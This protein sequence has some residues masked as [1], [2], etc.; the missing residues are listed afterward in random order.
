MAEVFRNFLAGRQL[1]NQEQQAQNLLAQQSVENERQNQLMQMRQTEFGNAQQDRERQL[2]LDAQEMQRQSAARAA[3]VA[4]QAIQLGGAQGEGEANARA[5][6]RRSV[7]IYGKDFSAVADDFSDLTND[8][9]PWQQQVQNLQQIAAFGQ[10]ED[11]ESQLKLGNVNP[12]DFT[13]QSLRAYQQSID[14][15]TGVGDFS[16]LER[17]WAPPAVTVREFGGTSN[18][19]DP[20]NRLGGGTV[21]QLLTPE[22]E[23]EAKA[24]EA[25][26]V[27]GAQTAAKADAERAAGAAKVEGQAEDVLRTVTQLKNSPG[28]PYILG[29]YSKAPIVPNTAQAAADALAKQ[30]EGQTFLQAFESLKGGGQITEIEG[31]QAKQAVSRLSRAQSVADYTDAL[32]ELVM[33][34]NRAVRRARGEGTT[35]PAQSGAQPKGGW[36]IEVVQ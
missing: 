3:A 7:P 16:V 17:V 5:F 8:A 34:A 22:Q 32:D 18:I 4:R 15:R 28:L 23:R 13:P 36:S 2:G 1:R 12:G 24:A 30:I 10:P 25:G 11:G 14:P 35:N 33:I 31:Q 6:L 27:S 9:I 19:V 21:R 29:W 26:A 20:G